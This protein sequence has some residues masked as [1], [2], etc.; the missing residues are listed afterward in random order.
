M[1]YLLIPFVGLWGAA[2]A[3]FVATCFVWEFMI[4]RRILGEGRDDV[5]SMSKYHCF[6]A[7]FKWLVVPWLFRLDGTE[8]ADDVT[9]ERCRLLKFAII[10]FTASA[11]CGL[12]FWCWH[13]VDCFIDLTARRIVETRDNP[14]P[15]PLPTMMLHGIP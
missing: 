6:S 1:T 11:A 7:G 13:G 10:L 4:R 5:R 15:P 2:V 3:S 9:W 8:F 14:L 12:P